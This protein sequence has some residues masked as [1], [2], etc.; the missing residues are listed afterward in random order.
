MFSSHNSK[1]IDCK[2]YWFQS[3]EGQGRCW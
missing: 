3:L 2:K 1:G